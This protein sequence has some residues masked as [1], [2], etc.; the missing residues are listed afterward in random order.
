M[1]LVFV[2]PSLNDLLHSHTWILESV[3]SPK[4][5]LSPLRISAGFKFSLVGNVTI[6]RCPATEGTTCTIVVI[7]DNKNQVEMQ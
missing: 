6:M 1:F 2:P 3:S 5:F 7:T 4:C